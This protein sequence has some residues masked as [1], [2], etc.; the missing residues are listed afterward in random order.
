MTVVNYTEHY[1]KYRYPCGLIAAHGQGKL[2]LYLVRM[3]EPVR[4]ADGKKAIFLLGN[5]Y[6]S[7]ECREP[8]DESWACVL[9]DDHE[10]WQLKEIGRS[11]LDRLYS[12]R[13]TLFDIFSFY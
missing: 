8:Q 6:L 3:E 7:T 11:E 13:S 5:Y 12:G 4:R 1:R 2:F 9:S 10:Y